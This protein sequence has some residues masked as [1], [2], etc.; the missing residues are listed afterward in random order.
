[1]MVSLLQDFPVI[2]PPNILALPLPFSQDQQHITSTLSENE[3]AGIYLSANPSDI[4]T[5]HQKLQMLSWS[6]GDQSKGQDMSLYSEDGTALRYQGMRIPI[7][8][9]YITAVLAFLHGMYCN[10][11][12]YSGLCAARSALSSSI[13]TKG[14]LKLSDHPPISR[15]LKGIYN[16]PPPL[17]KYVDIW[18]L[19]LLLKYY[20]QKEN[21]DCLEFK[22][23]VKKTVILFIILGVRRKQALFT[24]SVD[25]IVLKENKFI[26]LPSKTMKHTK[27]NRPLEPLIYHH[28][29]DNEKLC[30]G[31]RNTLV[32]RDIRD[33]IISYGKP[34]KPVSS[35][36][37]S[38]WIKDELSKAGV[39]T[40]VFN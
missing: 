31:I 37:I 13:T 16:R 18:D 38:R 9:M 15:Y 25:N 19:T 20:E 14:Y 26:L 33:L 36:T 21:N 10:G 8:Q 35:E 3:T 2:L 30:I 34:H 1:M 6:R 28:Y 4:Q 40:S 32:T 5:F 12:L 24:L 11:F 27:V 29:P 23:L 7:L 17:P 39:D 22:E